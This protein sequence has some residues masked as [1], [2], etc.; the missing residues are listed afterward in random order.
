MTSSSIGSTAYRRCRTRQRWRHGGAA[1]PP[2][3]TTRCC[4]MQ[5][6]TATATRRQTSWRARRRAATAA[7]APTQVGGVC[8][9]GAVFV[10]ASALQ[11]HTDAGLLV[12]SEFP[13]TCPGPADRAGMNYDYADLAAAMESDDD[14]SGEELDRE[15][16]GSGSGSGSEDDGEEGSEEEDDAELEPA[17]A[18]FSDMSDEE[19][20]G[21]GGS[22]GGDGDDSDEDGAADDSDDDSDLEFEAELAADDLSEGVCGA[23]RMLL[24]M[25]LLSSLLLLHSHSPHAS[26]CL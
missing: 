21:G 14:D 26:I 12:E 3:A 24:L 18:S 11:L 6:R 25:L 16:G 5:T 9:W 7:S 13:A 8:R 19:R 17:G 23:V 20:P 15:E 22:S 1:R 4:R 2:R 10:V